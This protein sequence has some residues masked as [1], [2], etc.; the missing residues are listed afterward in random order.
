MVL[1]AFVEVRNRKLVVR[2]VA[3]AADKPPDSIV[4]AF[5]GWVPSYKPDKS[6]R[7]LGTSGI[8]P[9]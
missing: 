4:V 9:F 5:C 2:V 1:P 8:R 7:R 6:V 3:G